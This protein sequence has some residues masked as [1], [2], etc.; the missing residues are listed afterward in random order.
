MKFGNIVFKKNLPPRPAATPPA[1]RGT[2][3]HYV[4]LGKYNLVLTTKIICCKTAT[5]SHVSQNFNINHSVFIIR[6]F[7]FRNEFQRS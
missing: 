5:F 1:R 2:H 3:P 7:D 6:Y 4:I